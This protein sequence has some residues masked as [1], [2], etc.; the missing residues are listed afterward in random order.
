MKLDQIPAGL[1]VFLG[2]GVGAS[3]RAVAGTNYPDAGLPLTTLTINLLGALLLGLLT[4]TLANWPT[5][6][7]LRRSLR[8]GVGTGMMGGFTTY[9]TFALGVIQLVQDQPGLALLY[10]LASLIGG[11]LC[12]WLGFK[13]AETFDRG[14]RA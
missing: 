12:C 4:G 5:E 13:I 2:G 7:A 1:L 6:N 8:L 10:I 3:L 11:I 9:S 14:R